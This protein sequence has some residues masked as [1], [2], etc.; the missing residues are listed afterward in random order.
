MT[1]FPHRYEA[2]LTGGPAGRGLISS[3]GLPALETAAPVEFGG[4]GDAWSPE[5]L[6]LAAI[7]ACFLFTFRAVARDSK[8]AYTTLDL[9]AVGV[10]D[11]EARTTRFTGV[12]LTARLTVAAGT[13]REHAMRVLTRAEGLCL[14][15]ASISTPIR[16]APEV[17]ESAGSARQIA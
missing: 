6:F 15:S 8:L 3:A 14:V 5:H 9:D 10:V 7:Q 16:L 2:H 17:I 4:P 1:P 13:D 11:R 12:V